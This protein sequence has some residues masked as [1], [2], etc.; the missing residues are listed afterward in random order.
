[1]NTPA[2]PVAAKPP[3]PKPVAP[4]TS[5]KPPL[6][7]RPPPPTLRPAVPAAVAKPAPHPGP[8]AAGA[9]PP[10][11]PGSVPK[12]VPPPMKASDITPEHLFQ[13]L[14]YF[15]NLY[16]LQKAHIKL[17]GSMLTRTGTALPVV[18]FPS[19]KSQAGDVD[20]NAG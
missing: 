4:A 14:S 19:L 9:K 3:A 2:S 6:P 10:P 16:R 18:S 7:T 17:L 15:E 5:A 20:P 1:M 11:S 13:R 8:L 12:R